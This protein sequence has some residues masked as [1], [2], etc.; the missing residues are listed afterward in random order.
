[1]AKKRKMIAEDLFRIQVPQTVEVSQDGEQ[2]VYTV[3]KTHGAKNT[4]S[5]DIYRANRGGGGRRAMTHG[6]SNDTG[7]IWSPDGRRV[8]FL[9]DRAGDV[10][11]IWTMP[12]D[13]GEPKQL[14]KLK[15]GPIM[16]ISWSP[17]G[18]SLL[19]LHRDVPKKDPEKAK[20][21]ASFKHITRLYHKLDGMGWY[22]DARW[23]LY[24]AS[25]PSGKVKA[26]TTGDRDVNE[27]CWS[28]D[29]KRIAFMQNGHEDPDR[30]IFHADIYVCGRDGRRAKKI[31]TKTGLRQSLAWS[32][33]GKHLYFCGNYMKAGEWIQHTV[34]VRKI[35]A[36]GG[37]ETLITPGVK[38]WTM[39]MVVTDT[40]SGFGGPTLVYRDGRE[41][42]I[43]YFQDEQGACR[44]YSASG[45]G[46]DERLEFGGNVN[47]AAFHGSR[48]G[49]AVA[50]A[51]EI[52][53]AGDLFS[54]TLDGSG[55]TKRLTKLND[56]LFQSLDLVEP[57]E[58]RVKNGSTK[59]QAWI[60][61]PPRM[62]KGAKY[63]CVL[64]VH[65]GP[66]CQ[67]GYTFF[68]EMHLLAAQG[69][70]VVATNPRGSSGQGLKY[71]NCI[72]GNWG[73]LDYADCM[74]AVDTMVRKPYVDG[75]RLGILGGSYGGFMTIWAVGHT[76]RFK[77]GVTQRA[78]GNWYTQFGSSDFG[79]EDQ[80]EMGG[81]PWDRPL[82]YL[83]KSPNFY[84]KN[85]KTPLLIVHS[86]QDHRCPISQAEELFTSLKVLGRTTE[87]VRFEGES[88][89]LSRGGK[90][91]N[92]LERLNRIVGW[93]ARYI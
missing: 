14:T 19:F 69:Y 11:N 7:A 21:E 84:V 51:A 74:A 72:E 17:D 4:Y 71:M 60:F 58:I 54:F 26:L 29:G 1:M 65:G 46:G 18:K 61:K 77:A 89:G 36:T 79:W 20:R 68:H 27:A 50:V 62:R 63:P 93:F 75:K 23:N 86:E 53:T 33:D 47:I 90:P 48:D 70:V 64:E 6:K 12:V 81:L 91:Q 66:M 59:V 78:L 76:N 55:E 25:F 34:P 73:K 9:S 87:L 16:G 30:H 38:N 45:S 22:G 49:R 15:G 67:Y 82:H 24:V 8:A 10:T 2:I 40:I 43:A 44:I 31:T 3:K 41:E 92:R 56:A 52:M 42:R 57:E 39:N 37:A 32:L 13:G 85:I 5:H 88:H 80:Y 35:A 83:K 28:P